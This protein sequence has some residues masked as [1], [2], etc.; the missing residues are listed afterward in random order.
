MHTGIRFFSIAFAGAMA[1]L[2]QA[3]DVTPTLTPIRAIRNAVT[4]PARV[5]VDPMGRLYLTDCASGRLFL[6]E[7]TGRL[8]GIRGGFDHPLGI[9]ADGAGHIYLGES[10][11]RRVLILN[12]DG[13]ILGHLGQGDGE[14]SLP[15][16]IA[17][18]AGSAGLVYVADSAANLI[19]VYS[20]GGSKVLEFG[21][22]GSGSGQFDF[23][24]GLYASLTEIFVSDQN[25][26]RIQVFDLQG[27]FLRSYGR[28]GMMGTGSPYGRIQGLAA[29]AQ[30][31]IYVADAFQGQIHVLSST[32][33]KLASL[34]TFGEGPGQ[35]TVPVSLA[36]DRNNRL[37]VVSSG[38]ARVEV[39]GID[40]YQDFPFLQAAF[41]FD[42]TEFERPPKGTPI[43]LPGGRFRPLRSD[44]NDPDPEVDETENPRLLAYLRQFV[45]ATLRV[46]GTDAT[47]ILPNTITVNGVAP[48][49]LAKN[50]AIE[51]NGTP[52]TDLKLRFT[53]KALTATLPDGPSTILVTGQ[54]VGGAWFEG[55]VTVDVQTPN[56][57]SKGGPRASRT[58]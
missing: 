53:I 28:A 30:G 31:R 6:R 34:A 42:R 25:N 40:A 39:F 45:G 2:A 19:K 56:P 54:V 38:N 27:Q 13:Q 8:L 23:P 12:T 55:A 14:F 35:L 46:Q 1:A 37:F 57:S 20:P 17:V 44:P 24:T 4:D 48:L 9:A 5:A 47:R 51:P 11:R 29:D 3:Q 18:G 21:A 49:G 22:P 15:N 32:G 26:N 52:S 7:E 43:G 33:V 50:A 36:V 16:H 41:S 10:G 58:R